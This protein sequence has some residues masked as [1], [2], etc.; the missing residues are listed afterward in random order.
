[1]SL[2]RAAG[3]AIAALALA[4]YL[5]PQAIGL[6]PAL[7]PTAAVVLFALGFWATGALPFHLTA[8]LL[9]LLALVLEIAPPRVIFAGFASSA[10]WLVFGGLVIGAAVQTTGLGRRLARLLV[11]HLRGSYRRIIYGTIALGVGLAFLV[12]AAMGRIMIMVPIFAALAG[13]LGL[14]RGSRGRTGIL[15]AVSFG[16][17][18]PAFAILPANLPNMVL[19][20]VSETLYDVSLTYTAFL[21][22]HFPVLGLLY[23]LLLAEL[24]CRLFPDRPHERPAVAEALPPWSFAERRLLAILVLALV[25]WATDS[26][27]GV[28]PGWVA[29]GA[30]VACMMPGL[31]VL[32]VRTFETVTS[33]GAFFYVAGLLG[34][35][36]MIDASGLAATLAETAG[37][38]LPVA[39]DAPAWNF[40]VLVLT[41]SLMALVTAQPGVPAVLG[42]LA[43]PI[44]EATGLPLISVLMTQVLGFAAI[45]L[46]YESAPVMVAVQL[47]NVGLG[48]ATRLSL[49]LG[50]LT[51]VLLV[52]VA[53]LW[54]RWLGYLS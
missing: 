45:L 15:L 3:G 36:S 54:W 51:L 35:V 25:L 22:L 41:A 4:L 16:T 19:L 10:L 9:F 20:G 49:L 21:L 43:G 8:L 28:S 47:A 52:P 27:H 46:P 14:A 13:E 6:A 5:W 42:P 50:S 17:I 40:G 1:V 12:P 26:L 33:F 39:P 32:D 30:A 37:R 38:W 18:L 7:A 44:A 23:A 53:Y 48:A 29:L 34:M 11:R 2:A 31:G 24:I